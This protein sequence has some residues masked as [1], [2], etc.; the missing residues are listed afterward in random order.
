MS[1]S[2]SGRQLVHGNTQVPQLPVLG[3]VCYHFSQESYCFERAVVERLVHWTPDQEVTASNPDG[4][5][6][7]RVSNSALS[8]AL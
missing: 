8:T 5:F 6:I 7:F 2:S 3:I 4:G 1:S